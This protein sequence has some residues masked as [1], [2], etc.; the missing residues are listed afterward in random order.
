L[1]AAVQRIRALQQQF[2]ND[3][4]EVVVVGIFFEIQGSND[5]MEKLEGA[6]QGE[7]IFI[8]KARMVP[9]IGR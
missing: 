9:K 7:G 2:P 1:N 8:R 3:P 4:L 5:F 6:V